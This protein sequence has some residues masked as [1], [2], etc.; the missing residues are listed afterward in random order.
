[1]MPESVHPR[2][3]H[4]QERVELDRILEGK[5]VRNSSIGRSASKKVWNMIMTNGFGGWSAGRISH[6]SL[7]VARRD[8]GPGGLI[9]RD[10]P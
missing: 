10:D 1:V 5:D 9:P 2:Q 6:P 3:Y 4:G 8:G 7:Q